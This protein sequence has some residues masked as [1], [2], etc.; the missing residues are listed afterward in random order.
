MASETITFANELGEAI[1]PLLNVVRRT[2]F[3]E[4]PVY[5]VVMTSLAVAI[6]VRLAR[7]L[8]DNGTFSVRFR[9]RFKV[10]L[11][12]A[13]FGQ[14]FLVTNAA[15]VAFKTL[16]VEELDYETLPWF[17]PYVGPL[18]FYIASV[19]AVNLWLIRRN[20]STLLDQAL[21]GYI[22]V[23]LCG[24]YAVALYRLVFEPFDPTDVTTAV[25][26]VV[27]M[28]WFGLLNADVLQRFFSRLE[29]NDGWGPLRTLLSRRPLEE[30]RS[31]GSHITGASK[32][33]SVNENRAIQ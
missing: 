24:G 15:A 3:F 4:A 26:G 33:G 11:L 17:A 18:H 31:H 30:I 13:Y 16:I 32:A 21:C 22:Q 20:R 1:G 27:L 9:A 29:L 7:A 14:C 28:L 8:Q 23:G 5:L 25:S 6:F 2:G 12:I 19:A 10:A